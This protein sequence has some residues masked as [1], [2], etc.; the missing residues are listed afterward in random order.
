MDGDNAGQRSFISSID[1]P[2]TGSEVWNT[3]VGA[4]ST[5]PT[6]VRMW[7]LKSQEQKT[8]NLSDMN[9]PVR[10]KTNFIGSKMYL[11]VLVRGNTNAFPVSI[12]GIQLF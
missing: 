7:G 12:M 11:E 1:D 3:S 5:N 10:F 6:T 8:V 9:K 2:G 4:L